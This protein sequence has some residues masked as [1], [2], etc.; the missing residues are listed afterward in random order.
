METF[1]LFLPL[2]LCSYSLPSEY[3]TK[4]KKGGGYKQVCEHS[5]LSVTFYCVLCAL[6]RHFERPPMWIIHHFAVRPYGSN[7]PEHAG[8]AAVTIHNI[9]L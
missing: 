2:C 3:Y 4:S 9:G 7:P 6:A 8:K 1:C 5:C